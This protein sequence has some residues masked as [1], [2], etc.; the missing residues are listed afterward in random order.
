MENDAKVD[1]NVKMQ[2]KLDENRAD[3]VSEAESCL[4]SFK[5]FSLVGFN[6]EDKETLSKIVSDNGG[7]Q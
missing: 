1:E 7:F 4:F 5:T 6:E 2:E 3:N